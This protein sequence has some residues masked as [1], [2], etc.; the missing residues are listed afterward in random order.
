MQISNHEPYFMN[1]EFVKSKFAKFVNKNSLSE[2]EFKKLFNQLKTLMNDNTEKSK[3]NM[4]NK[5]GEDFKD[6]L[7]R[8]K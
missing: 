8:L 1:G 7:E 3:C 6:N 2:D 4:I 5:S